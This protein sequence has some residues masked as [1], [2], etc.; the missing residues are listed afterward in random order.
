MAN[1]LEDDYNS[2]LKW[3]SVNHA[4]TCPHDNLC[5]PHLMNMIGRLDDNEERLHVAF[6]AIDDIYEPMSFDEE[7]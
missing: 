3:W 5:G 4:M 1:I 7:A 6:D 2:C